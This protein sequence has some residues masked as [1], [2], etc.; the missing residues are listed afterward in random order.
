MKKIISIV[1]GIFIIAGVVIF[2]V[3]SSKKNTEPKYMP[4]PVLEEGE[5][6]DVVLPEYLHQGSAAIS[7]VPYMKNEGRCVDAWVN[8]NG[9]L[10]VKLDQETLEKNYNIFYD[11]LMKEI[12]C[13]ETNVKEEV[14]YDYTKL[15]FYVN[16][17]ATLDEFLLSMMVTPGN[18]YALQLLHGIPDEEAVVE[19]VV[20][21][22]PTGKEILII[23]EKTHINLNREDWAKLLESGR[24]LSE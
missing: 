19:V 5:T 2:Y 22:E 16:D 15:T 20:I 12:N 10:V 23:D 6:M 17:N 21:Y 14:S 7:M 18:C 4:C 9:E 8:D 24:N 1:L 3:A 11:N 13:K